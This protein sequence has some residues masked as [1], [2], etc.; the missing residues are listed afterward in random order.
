MILGELHLGNTVYYRYQ[1]IKL[2]TRTPG[3]FLIADMQI[4]VCLHR[5]VKINKN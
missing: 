2:K 1:S 5:K 4:W 3:E